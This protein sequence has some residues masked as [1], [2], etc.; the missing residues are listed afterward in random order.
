MPKRIIRTSK[1]NHQPSASSDLNWLKG[2]CIK[3]ARNFVSDQKNNKAPR[4]E[5]NRNRKLKI[6]TSKELAELLF[7]WCLRNVRCHFCGGEFLFLEDITINH[8]LPLNEGG[9][10]LIENFTPAHQSCNHNHGAANDP[11]RKSRQSLTLDQPILK[12]RRIVYEKHSN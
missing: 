9:E 1:P 8:T 6:C 10:S 4:I 12:M 5:R 7:S 11:S 3:K 2:R